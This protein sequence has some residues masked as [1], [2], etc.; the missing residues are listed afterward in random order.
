MLFRSNLYAARTPVYALAD[1]VVDA[2]PDLSVD[3]MA[4]KV[5]KALALHPDVLAEGD[6]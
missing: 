6:A 3:G 2:A 1:I 4:Q 5:I